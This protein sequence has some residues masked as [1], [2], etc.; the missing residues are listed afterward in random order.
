MRRGQRNRRKAAERQDRIGGSASL[1][2]GRIAEQAA[3]AMRCVHAPGRQD[4]HA[5]AAVRLRSSNFA[6]IAE[7]NP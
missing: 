6:L 7:L 3:Q 5:G 2:S 4:V 1:D